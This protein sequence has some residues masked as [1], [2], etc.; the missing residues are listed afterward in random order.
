MN[1]PKPTVG[2]LN[3]LEQVL[4][5]L[6]TNLLVVTADHTEG[7]FSGNQDCFDHDLI[8]LANHANSHQAFGFRKE[9]IKNALVVG[10]S[11]FV[12][13]KEGDE[14]QIGFV[15]D[16]LINLEKLKKRVPVSTDIER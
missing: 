1:N 3:I 9:N 10:A 2:S 14:F 12:Q 4:Q 7:M 13:D 11:L 6:D 8:W 15:P 5:M 16:N